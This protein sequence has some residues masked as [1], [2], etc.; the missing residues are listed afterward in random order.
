MAT[1]E[2]IV[3]DGCGKEE[4]QE[5]EPHFRLECKCTPET[6]ID[7]EGQITAEHMTHVEEIAKKRDAWYASRIK[8]INVGPRSVIFHGSSDLLYC[9]IPCL[10]EHVA[11]NFDERARE[12][13]QCPGVF[14]LGVA[15][16]AHAPR[17]MR[18]IRHR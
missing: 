6:A 4:M 16:P 7:A 8:W 15:V 18:P 17:P 12:A 2:F 1:K 11:R 3:C 9:S 14:G 13:E 5:H 10:R